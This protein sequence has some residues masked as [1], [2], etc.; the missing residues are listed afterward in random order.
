MKTLEVL[1]RL[2]YV[3]SQYVVY[4]PEYWPN[5]QDKQV[6]KKLIANTS[7]DEIRLESPD[8]FDQYEK[9]QAVFD[10]KL[11]L[12]SIRTLVESGDYSICYARDFLNARYPKKAKQFTE[13]HGAIW[14]RKI[15]E[16]EEWQVL[17]ENAEFEDAHG[18]ASGVIDS[19]EVTLANYDVDEAPFPWEDLNLQTAI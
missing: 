10:P 6:V 9:C 7:L 16:D 3:L 4:P 15:D 12:R 1:F 8:L 11:P 5:L 13:L 14:T 18:K 2:E 17:L 19:G